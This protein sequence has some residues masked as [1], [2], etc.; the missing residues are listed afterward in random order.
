[1]NA[2]GTDIVVKT[3][4]CYKTCIQSTIGIQSSNFTHANPVERTKTSTNNNFSIGL[5]CHFL[6]QTR[7]ARTNDKASINSSARQNFHYSIGGGSIKIRKT[8]H[9]KNTPIGLQ[10]HIIDNTIGCSRRCSK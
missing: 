5:K 9:Q 8:S 6:D 4:T 2:Y 1:M 3:N 7:S 10:Y